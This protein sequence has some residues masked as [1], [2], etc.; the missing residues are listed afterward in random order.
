MERGQRFYRTFNGQDGM[1]L[2][3]TKAEARDFESAIRIQV[4]KG[5]YSKTGELK[6]FGRFFDEVF[7]H[8]AK[9]HKASWRHD[10]FRGE[11]LKAFFFGK[12]FSQITP[13]LVVSYI[14]HRL[15][16]L[17]KRKKLLN[18]VTVYKELRLLSSVFNMAMAEQ[19]A[20]RNPC[21]SIPRSVKKKLPARNKRDCVLGRDE[22]PLLFAQ[23]VG[24]RSHLLAPVRFTVETGLRKSELCRLEV[25]HV[26]LGSL[27]KFFTIDNQ[28]VA[29]EPNQLLVVKSKNGKPRTLPLS[30][31]ARRIA[32]HQVSDFTN[33]KYLFTSIKGGM[34]TEI[35]TGFAGAVRDAGLEDFRFHDLRHTFSTRLNEG[36]ADPFTVRDLLG[37][38]T[39]TMS[40]DYTHSTAE[41][42]RLAIE[43]MSQNGQRVSTNYVKIASNG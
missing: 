30:A 26:N 17:S 8:Y 2:A 18:P 10:E 43:G 21:L 35:K 1:P 36:R 4:R 25:E 5:T 7:L 15:Q 22:E 38:S 13:M 16:S 31:E 19:I 3:H 34:I 40:S 41:T 42:R 12:K 33:T 23:L 6:D 32:E 27:P 39:V 14:N 29:L 20:D 9:A 28:K 37:H 24:R 11:V